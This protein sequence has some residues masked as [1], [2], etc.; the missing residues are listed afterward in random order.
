MDVDLTKW[1]RNFRRSLLGAALV[2]GLLDYWFS[3]DNLWFRAGF[4]ITVA[5]L[6]GYFTNFLAIKMLFQP[7]QGQVLGWQGLVPKNKDQIAKSLAESVQEQLL[8]PEIILAYIREREL[9]EAGTNTIADWVDRNLQDPK[10]R[11]RI[12][13]LLVDLMQDKGPDALTRS[14]ITWRRP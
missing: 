1:D 14:W 9:I 6:V 4:V 13:R 5:G 12:T 11:T 3:G 7:K 10:V 8:S 2:F